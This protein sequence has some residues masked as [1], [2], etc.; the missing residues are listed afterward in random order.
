MVRRGHRDSPSE[1]GALH[2]PRNGAG[3]ERVS[4]TSPFRREGAG[5]GAPPPPP[6]PLPPLPEPAARPLP[7]GTEKGREAP[8]EAGREG[9]RKA[10]RESRGC[11]SRPDRP[12][13]TL[14]RGDRGPSA[15]ARGKGASGLRGQELLARP[16]GRPGPTPA[17]PVRLLPSGPGSAPS[18]DWTRRT[19]ATASP[20]DLLSDL[21]QVLKTP[22]SVSKPCQ[23]GTY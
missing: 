5:L 13:C 10:R 4:F 6:A 12:L 11:A 1:H 19:G 17:G 8:G 3:E 22:A 20:S 16:P 7:Q 21:G 14:R 18:P 23:Q 9:A 15:W 2:S